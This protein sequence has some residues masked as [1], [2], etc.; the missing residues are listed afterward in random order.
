MKKVIVI[1]LGTVALAALAGVTWRA[2]RPAPRG[3]A[4]IETSGRIEGDQAAVGSKIGGKIV[5]L[6][7]REGERVGAG[8]AIVEL[9]SEQVRAELERADHAVHAAREAVG[10]ARARV[11]AAERRAQAATIAVSLAEHESRARI[12]EAG[13]ALGAARARVRQ[14]EADLERA[15]KDHARAQ[16]L[17]R[18]ELIAAQRA[19][20]TTAAWEVARA[21]VDAAGKQVTQAEQALELARASRIA[22]D[23]RQREAQTAGEQ[24][25]EARA[26]VATARAEVQ[27]AEATRGLARAN[28][29]DT[30]VAAPFSGTVLEKLVE[31]GQVVAPGT[32]LVTFVDLARLHAKVYVAEAQLGRVKVGDPARVYTDAFARRAFDATVAEVAEQAE[33]TPRDVHR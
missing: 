30:T 12:G 33:F 13:A 4:V 32:P 20:E 17:F 9:S 15:S 14:A 21:T 24:V 19:D 29:E 25:V 7:V 8:A 5:R 22:V 11:A 23:V 6:A 16:E 10:Q 2:W 31:P 1:T 27:A 26:A 18:K 3:P 28:V